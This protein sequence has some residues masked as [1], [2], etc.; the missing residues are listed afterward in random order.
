MVPGVVAALAVMLAGF[1]LADVLGHALLA[2]QGL[3]GGSPISGVPVA[4][5]LGLLLRNSLPLPALLTP[6]TTV[7]FVESGGSR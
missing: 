3:S 2:A 4:I 5:V 7:R 1:W 6:G